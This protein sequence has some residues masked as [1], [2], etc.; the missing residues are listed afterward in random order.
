M[1]GEKR[2]G[3]M[4]AEPEKAHR[5]PSFARAEALGG[6]LAGHFPT[7]PEEAAAWRPLV[8]H[9]ALASRVL[10]V[11]ATRVEFAWAA[12]VDAVPGQR[13]E[14]EVEAV[15]ERGT[16]LAEGVARALFPVFGGVPYAG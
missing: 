14:E 16:K 6:P 12:Y 4:K 5:H 9:R 3:Q 10:A 13:H 7:S 15:R 1:S 2:S 11:A 8:L